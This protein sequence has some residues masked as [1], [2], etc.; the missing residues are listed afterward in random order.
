[1]NG[2]SQCH[3]QRHFA[4]ARC[5]R[6]ELDGPLAWPS[7]AA[8]LFLC[9]CCERLGVLVVGREGICFQNELENKE[10]QSNVYTHTQSF[11]A[12]SCS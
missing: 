5:W 4:F 10:D 9:S 6:R 3:L 1:M 12:G 8:L 2:F 7:V 11:L